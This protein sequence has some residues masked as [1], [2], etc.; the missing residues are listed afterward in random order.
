MTNNDRNGH[1][2][3]DKK[4]VR[5]FDDLDILKKIKEN[6]YFIISSNEINKYKEARLMTKFDYITQL[7]DI[8]YHNKLS[9]LP[10]KR[11]EYVIGPFETHQKLSTKDKDFSKDRKEIVFP[12]W[13]E[14]INHEKITSEATML[15]S[16]VVSGMI[17]DLFN[18]N[19]EDLFLTIS[20][21]MSSESFSYQINQT[22]APNNQFEIEVENSQIEI[23]G[24]Y[25]TPD[26]LILVE[27]KNNSTDSFLIRQLFYPYRLWKK[28]VNKEVIPVFLQYSHGTFN[29]S[30]FKFND[31]FDY[32]SIQLIERRNY[33]FGDE[34]TSMGDLIEIF[35]T[36]PIIDEPT[37]VP[38][39]QANSFNKVIGVM[40]SIWDSENGYVTNEDLTIEN[41]FVLRQANYYS[42]AAIY[43]GFVVRG[44][45][46]EYYLSELG[47]SFFSKNRRG[48]NLMIAQA[49]LQYRP[50]REAF[51]KSIEMAQQLTGRETALVLEESGLDYNINKT[52]KKRRASTVASWISYLIQL[53][54]DY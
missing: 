4:W 53:I 19:K 7:P 35:R 26:K 3:I 28:K 43:L 29:F 5:I 45:S 44:G 22:L 31:D 18:V 51:S 23:D 50:F 9:I 2:I 14:S 54:D 8:F 36:T 48:K 41:D 17:Q 25:E 27:A 21:R 39:P 6:G 52:T 15:N 13:I 12:T 16:A 42:S 20:G 46:N 49:I 38:F 47:K 30:I 40:E 24:G 33:I 37:D 34:K 11:G 10:T 32:N 1:R